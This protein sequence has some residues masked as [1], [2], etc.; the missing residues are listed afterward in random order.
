[1]ENWEHIP[2][3]VWNRDSAEKGCGI[4]DAADVVTVAL[5][6][7]GGKGVANNGGGND[8]CDVG[9]DECIDRDGGGGNGIPD[10]I[11]PVGCVGGGVGF[12]IVFV[13]TAGDNCALQTKE[14]RKISINKEKCFLFLIYDL[15]LMILVLFS[16]PN[17][18]K[19]VLK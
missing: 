5:D 2:L 16:W 4:A 8:E 6:D 3:L 1:M 7:V 19:F 11:E 13:T 12:V 14:N 9:V 15:S 17:R 10:E 18:M